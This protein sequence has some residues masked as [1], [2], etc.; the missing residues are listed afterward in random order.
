MATKLAT[1]TAEGAA[2]TEAAHS[3][4]NQDTN[5]AREIINKAAVSAQDA[6]SAQED[7][8]TSGAQEE[9]PHDSAPSAQEDNADKGAQVVTVHEGAPSHKKSTPIMA[10]KEKPLMRALKMNKRMTAN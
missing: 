6:H 2:V 9:A 5:M 4:A 3:S 10:H 8:A 1:K 7:N